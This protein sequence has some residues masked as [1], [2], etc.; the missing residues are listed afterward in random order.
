MRISVITAVFNREHVIER[1]LESVNQQVGVEVEHIIVDNCSSDATMT[2][3][4]K[5]VTPHS[6]V[7]ISEPD[8]GIYDGLN[9][10]LRAATGDIVGFLHSDDTFASPFVLQKTQN[11]FLARQDC[12][13]FFG[14]VAYLSA[15]S[16]DRIRR[17]YSSR[18]IGYRHL[19]LGVSPAHPSLF[20]KRSVLDVVG[21][22]DTSYK[23]AGDFEYFC[24]L[25]SNTSIKLEYGDY[26][27]TLML[28]AGASQPSLASW[29]KISREIL[30]A[31]ETNNIFS[32]I[33]VVNVRL[34]FKLMQV[35]HPVSRKLKSSFS[36]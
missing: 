25:F 30:R 22:Y 16:A 5:N 12:D 9:K 18:N 17:Y 36:P 20:M 1:A 8:D 26:L 23:I 10:G 24:R 6:R 33:F 19:R 4:K 15:Q 21:Y 7:I 2:I 27:S 3:V 34:P 31:C 32:N 29:R 14:D 13:A 11:Q 28:P 35:L